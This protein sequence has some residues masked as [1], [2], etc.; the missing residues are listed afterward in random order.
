MESNIDSCKLLHDPGKP[1]ASCGLDPFCGAN[2]ITQLMSSTHIPYVNANQV[3]GIYQ[4]SSHHSRVEWS[5][6]LVFIYEC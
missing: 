1:L 4:S 6:L 5:H 2:S 3:L